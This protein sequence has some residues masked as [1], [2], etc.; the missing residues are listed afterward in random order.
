MTMHRFGNVSVAAPLLALVLAL[1]ASSVA[2]GQEPPGGPPDGVMPY[3][4]PTIALVQPEN[5]T[6]VPDDKP[7]ILFRFAPGEPGDPLDVS[8]SRVWVDGVDRSARFTVT[9]TEAWGPIR[10]VASGSRRAAPRVG[11]S[12]AHRVVARVCSSRGACAEARATVTVVQSVVVAREQR[13]RRTGWGR[14]LD[15]LLWVIRKLVGR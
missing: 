13:A 10:R 3:R 12:G 4:A 9:A 15:A 8:S 14:V 5:G 2:A 6:P 11:S 1:R 7:V